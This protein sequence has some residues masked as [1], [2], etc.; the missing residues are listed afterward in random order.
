MYSSGDILSEGLRYTE[1]KVVQDNPTGHRAAA[2][3]LLV[4]EHIG[5][6]P[7]FLAFKWRLV[8]AEASA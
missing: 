2:P 1:A 6:G 5:R 3:T 8:F 7:S 4:R